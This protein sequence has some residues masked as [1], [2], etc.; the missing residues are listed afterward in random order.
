M[1]LSI[2][3]L[4][5]KS[6]KTITQL[7]EE[8]KGIRTGRANPA[9]LE[10]LMVETYGGQTHLKLM[11][12]ASI[13][14]NDASTLTIAPYDPSTNQDI[15]K[16]ILKS[17]LGLSP[18]VQ[19]TKL[20]I[21]IPPLSE[22]QRIKII[23]VVSQKIEEKKNIIRNMR[24]EVRKKIKHSFEAKDITEDQRYRS[25]KEADTATQQA[26]ESIQ[27]IKDRKEKELMEV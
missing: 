3:E 1:D 19:G 14:N 27:E 23:K 5:D 21:R 17:P 12:I 7:K 15:E 8:L 22:E 11:E 13:V 25:E 2:E 6:Q 4:K 24:D 20:I 26:M 18:Q 9:L 10:N 16:A